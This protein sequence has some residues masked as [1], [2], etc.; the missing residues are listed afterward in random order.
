MNDPCLPLWVRK[1]NNR[2]KSLQPGKFSTRNMV[3]SVGQAMYTPADKMRTD[4]ILNDRPYAGWLYL[5]LGWN[6][7]DALHLNTVE[8]DV[9]VVGP[10][11]MAQQSQNFIHD[12]R[13]L[14]RFAGWDNQLH[15]ELG[16]Q[17]V[18]ERK[19]RAFAYDTKSWPSSDLIT[20]YGG[21]LGNVKTYLN[22][23]VEIRFGIH[24]PDDFG[25][26]SIGPASDSNAPLMVTSRRRLSESGLHIFGA[27][28]TRIVLHDIFLDGNTLSDSHSIDK[29]NFVG[30]LAVGISWQWP[31]WKLTNSQIK[32]SREFKAQPDAHTFSSVT[33]SREY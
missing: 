14:D 29:R 5:G 24:L 17:L 26:A 18:S 27:I 28:D 15:N 23:G 10:A 8:L 16:V 1:L 19:T 4:V 6:A 20:H 33:V 22:A 7:R 3:I 32:R 11:S 13:S 31:G 21:S 30:D 2:S 9:G 12:L 25:T